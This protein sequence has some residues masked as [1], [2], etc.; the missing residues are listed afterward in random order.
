MTAISNRLRLCLS[1]GAL[2]ACTFSSMAQFQGFAP[3]QGYGTIQ[4]PQDTILADL[5]NDGDLD[6]GTTISGPDTFDEVVVLL[7]NGDGTFGSATMFGV[8]GNPNGLAA[9]DMDLDGDIDLLCANRDSDDVSLL[10]NNG[11][12]TFLTEVIIPAGSLPQD[13]AVADFNVDG[14]PDFVV[15]NADDN[16]HVRVYFGDASGTNWGAPTIWTTQN[17]GGTGGQFPN[18]V[19]AKDLNFDGA[20]DI[21]TANQG[22]DT[23]SVL[24]NIGNGTFFSGDFAIFVTT[25]NNP[26]D[27][28]CSDMNGDGA[29]DLVVSNRLDNTISVHFNNSNGGA[30]TFPSFPTSNTTGTGG[31]PEG[32][33]TADFGAEEGDGDQDLLVA[34]SGNLRVRLNTG[35]GSFVDGGTF[36]FGAGSSEPAA[37]D[38]DGDGDTDAVFP[39]P[40]TDEVGVFLNQSIIIGGAD[41]VARI[42]SPASFGLSGS[43]ICLDGSDITGVADVP[44]GVFDSYLLEYRPVSDPMG[45]VTIVNSMD[46]VAEPGGVLGTM[47]VGGLGEG[48]YLIRLTVENSS[49]ISDTA[50]IVVWV[51]SNYNSLD[52]FFAK[53]S[54]STGD[55]TSA[56]IVGG[57]ACLYGTANDNNCGPDEYIAEFSEAGAESWML[58]D[59]SNPVFT[60]NR[61][62]SLLADWDTTAVGDGAYDVRI[63]AFNGCGDSRTVRRDGILVDNTAPIAEI[64][65]P[66]N[67]DP[68]N[69]IGLLDISGTAFDDNIGS[70]SLAYTGGDENNWVSIAS[71]SNNVIDDVIASWDISSLRPCAYTIRLRVSDRA[72]VNCDSGRLREFYT[73]I[74]IGCRADLA[75]PYNE[76]DFSDV[77]AFLTAYGAGCP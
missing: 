26:G 33:I 35:A 42:D 43:C 66:L 16:S 10:R 45:W 41:P 47:N 57:N 73:S 8:G 31:T 30:M 65:S 21:V 9:A 55:M 12:G 34:T 17:G 64:S 7:N 13:I 6:I 38:L 49:G 46:S 4:S 74:N 39:S 56:E 67:C 18:G 29:P 36:P 61:L 20:P 32:V 22:S 77:L 19:I 50:E 58:V 14:K 63:I 28:A 59:G 75:E 52:W 70:W 37:G 72:I 25:G 68:F 51:S 71:G 24:Y 1:V 15:T 2:G 60:G 54:L 23:L 3:A 48:L 53:R 11:N 5:D 27:L 76:L 69:P 44:D 40:L 62:N